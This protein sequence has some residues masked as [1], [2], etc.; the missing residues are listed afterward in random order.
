MEE[1]IKSIYEKPQFWTIG[2]HCF[3]YNNS[4]SF[5]VCGGL[6]SLRPYNHAI[7]MTFADKV[8]FW[9]AFRWWCKNAPLETFGKTREVV[10][11]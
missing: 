11:Q 10:E 1:L 8:R 7:N 2:E 5:W 9:I 3:V 4:T 6:V